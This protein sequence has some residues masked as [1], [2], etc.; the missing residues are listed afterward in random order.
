MSTKSLMTII[1]EQEW[2]DKAGEAIQ[3]VILDA[4]K[5][6]GKT[7]NDI[8]NFLH[9]KWLGH[10]VH[11]MVTDVPIGAWTTAAVL[12]AMELC[13]SRKYK[14]GA[15]AAV[16]IGLAGATGAAISGLTDWTG[17]T[18]IERKAG[19]AHA[20]LNISATALYLTS[21]ILRKKERSRKTAISLS[22]LGYCVTTLSAFIGGNL[23]YN[24]QMG[25]NHTAVPE[26][27]PN[28]FVAVLPEDE[29]TENTMKCVRAEKVDVLLAKKGNQI[30]A[31]A[32]TCSHMGGPLA[33]G[34]LLEDCKVRCPWHRSVF[35]LRDGSVIDGPATE[36]QPEFEVRVRNGQIEVKLKD[37]KS[38][39]FIPP[40]S[41]Q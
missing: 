20:I 6:G 16:T 4:F 41:D 9:G 34:E 23:V 40:P 11:P 29:L 35:S 33:E 13:G 31:I 5:A 38:R 21:A 7:G 10:P 39:S 22:M 37:Q 26:G 25:V 1:D 30:F 28:D 14:P 12:D 2:L 18:Q 19:L 15:D 17:T 36:P 27:Y 24:Q 3:P 8:K 32:N